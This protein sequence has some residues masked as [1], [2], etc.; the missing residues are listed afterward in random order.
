MSSNKRSQSHRSASVRP[1]VLAAFAVLALQACATSSTQR[2]NDPEPRPAA[3]TAGDSAARSDSTRPAGDSATRTNSMRSADGSAAANGRTAAARLIDPALART[4][5]DS[6]WNR[7]A[8]TYYDTT[9]RGLDWPAVHA[10]Y[11]PVADTTTTLG[12]LRRLLSRMLA[13]LGE[14]HMAIIPG[15]AVP[16]QAA[17][18]TAPADSPGWSGIGLRLVS[19]ELLVTEV[20]QGSPAERLGIREGWILR[21]AGSIS[22]DSL[23]ELAATTPEASVARRD[24]EMRVVALMQM[25]LRDGSPGDTVQAVFTNERGAAVTSAIELAEPTGDFVRFG[26]LPTM[27]VRSEHERITTPGGC[28]SYVYLSVWMPVAMPA[29]ERAIDADS[30]CAGLILDLRGNPGG[31]AG[32]VMRIGGLVLNEPVHLGIM[33]S[34]TYE[35]KFAVNPRRV[36]A[37][38]E[39]ASPYSGRMAI[40]VD[41]LSLST[42]EIVAGSLQEIGRAR[43]FGTG[44]TGQALPSGMI[45]LPS[46]D[47]LLHAVA[48]YRTPGGKR[49]EGTGVVPDEVV[50]VTRADLLAGKDAPLE[51]ALQ[52]IAAPTP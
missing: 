18:P 19:D 22:A 12:D 3:R 16:D 42:S 38:G 17:V 11:A 37:G 30:A 8:N 21:S 28:A 15:E 5:L 47:V 10:E 6:V 50:L 51:A 48:D 34:R 7:I 27:R 52:W 26:N 25:R 39:P 35:L 49:V 36:R 2:V 44:T 1:V 20:E 14:S 29:V 4:T 43:V 33:Q 45:R 9:F 40:L 24:S 31:V 32:L 41:E 13:R 46:G 23:V